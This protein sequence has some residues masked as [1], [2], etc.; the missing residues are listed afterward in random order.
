M[1]KRKSIY[2]GIGIVLA[3]TGISCMAMVKALLGSNIRALSVIVVVLSLILMARGQSLRYIKA[4]KI[5]VTCIFLYSIITLFLSLISNVDFMEVEYGFIYQSVYFLQI[6]LLW[7]ICRD[8]DTDYIV[9]FGFWFTGIF[10]AISLVLLVRY[11]A[12]GLLFYNSYFSSSGE[13][14]FKR[15]ATGTLS[16]M[17]FVF[18]MSYNPKN[19]INK[20][21][22]Y[23]FLIIATIVVVYSTRRSVYAAFILC[24]ILKFRNDGNEL[25]RISFNKV[26]KSVLLTIIFISAIIIA[27]RN[28]LEVR[29]TFDKVWISFINGLRTILRVDTSDMAASM[30]ANT[31]SEVIYQYF[32]NSTLLQMLFGRGYM[33][34]YVDMPFIQAFWDMGF[35]GG[36]S[37]CILQFVVPIKYLV[38]R[39]RNSAVEVAQYIASFSIVNGFISNTPYGHFFNV[40][41]LITLC[42][43]EEIQGD[44][45]EDIVS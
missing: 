28:S 40:V 37:F 27:Y 3:L 42:D 9:K 6:V 35:V 24:I 21:I 38:H 22:R 16:F 43:F 8:I 23:F 39:P 31:A 11:A 5:D 1:E 2:A 14:I 36:I 34:T 20:T 45:N 13:Y 44:E 33:T 25:K 19:R 30:R 32:N 26:I 4:P 12:G 17:T 18:A 7:N 41:F 29:Q 15:S 10:C